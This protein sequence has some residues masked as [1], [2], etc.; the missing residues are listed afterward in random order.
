LCWAVLD[1]KEN[2]VPPFPKL[3]RA[4]EYHSQAV[5]LE[6]FLNVFID[7]DEESSDARLE[8]VYVKFSHAWKISQGTNQQL[9]K[10]LLKA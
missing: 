1:L 3:P 8:N 4:K 10:T 9:S 2:N 5:S 7:N 6:A